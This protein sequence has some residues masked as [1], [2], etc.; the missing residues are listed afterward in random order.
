MSLPE[1]LALKAVAFCKL[2]VLWGFYSFPEV[3]LQDTGQG[4]SGSSLGPFF[5]IFRF[6]FWI[7]HRR[8]HT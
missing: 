5:P 3:S 8:F 6:Y 2:P 4:P 1:C 7:C